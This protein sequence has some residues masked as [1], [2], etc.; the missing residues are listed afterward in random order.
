[1][2]QASILIIE[3][4]AP[5]AHLFAQLWEE[6]G[7]SV[8][9]A[10]SQDEARALLAADGLEA[11]DVVI[12]YDFADEGPAP[13]A[14][15]DR[16]GPWTQAPMLALAGFQ[17]TWWHVAPSAADRQR[18][19]AEAPRVPPMPADVSLWYSTCTLSRCDMTVA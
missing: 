4:E 7:Y 8:A 12:C 14:W 1:M 9:C 5:I 18:A 17:P 19:K 16:L 15:L 6:H 11:F 10:T 3:P 2:A 13:Y